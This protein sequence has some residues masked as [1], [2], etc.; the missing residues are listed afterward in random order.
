MNNEAP[1]LFNRNRLGHSYLACW[2][3]CSSVTAP[4]WDAPSS[5]LAQQAKSLVDLVKGFINQ[6]TWLN[7]NFRLLGRRGVLVLNA[8]AGMDQLSE[9]E[10]M[11]P[12]I[13]Q[14]VSFTSGNRYS[15]FDSSTDHLATYGLAALVAGGVA[16]KLG[17]FKLLW[18]G[19]LASYKFIL[20]GLAA[21]GT[22]LRKVWGRF[23]GP[24]KPQFPPG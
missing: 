22:Y 9:V 4:S 16:A 7:Y 15:E 23:F 18:I 5:R 11:T 20:I 8:V 6:D 10:R 2:L 1:G 3:R 21:A 13:L 19:I 17:F 14:S 24:R 12:A